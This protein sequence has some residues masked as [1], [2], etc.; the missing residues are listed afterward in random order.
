ML[1]VGNQVKLVSENKNDKWLSIEG[2]LEDQASKIFL[3]NF[4]EHNL[5]FTVE[6]LYG[7]KLY[8]FQEITL[9]AWFKRNFNMS[10]WGRGNSKSWL[11]AVFCPLYLIFNP[12]SKL[13]VCST[14]FR[15]CA[16]PDTWVVTNEGMI[17]LKYVK[18]NIFAKTQN[19]KITNK[20]VNPPEKSIKIK[21]RRNYAIEGL[22]DHKIC[23]YNK[24]SLEFEY[25]ELKDVTAETLI[26]I[27]YGMESWGNLDLLDGYT[28]PTISNKG[29][30]NICNIDTDDIDLYYLMGLILGDGYIKTNKY[31]SHVTLAVGDKD[32]ETM[33]FFDKIIFKLLGDKVKVSRRKN[34]TNCNLIRVN[35]R[36]FVDFLYHV[37][38]KKGALADK[39]II[40]EKI[41]KC[42]KIKIA[43]FLKGLFDSDGSC[44]LRKDKNDV[45][46]CE[47]KLA[48]SSEEIAR[49][50]QTLLLNFGIISSITEEK[51]RGEMYIM[52]VKTYGKKSYSLKIYGY[53]NLKIFAEQIG[54]RLLRKQANLLTYLAKS[55][56]LYKQDSIV[57]PNIGL[58]LKNKY[59]GIS[60]VRDNLSMYTLK[61][62]LEMNILSNE[63]RIKL[64]RICGSKFYIDSIRS[65][66]ESSCETIDIE[67]ENEHCYFGNG[68]INHNS[69]AILYQTEQFLNGK[70]ADLLRQCFPDGVKRKPDEW[71]IEGN[72]G[73]IKALP[74]SN[75]NLRGTRA[76][77]L[78][79]DEMLLI[80]EEL[81]KTILF[82]FL[83]AKSNIQQQMKLDEL[84]ARVMS[85]G[86]I[87]EDQFNFANTMKKVIC[88]SSA[89]YEFEYLYKLY[90]EWI[91]NI[92]ADKPKGRATYFISQMSYEAVP[93][94]LIDE[95]V[96]EEART[97]G[98]STSIF[99]REFCAN[100]INDSSSYFSARKMHECTIPD[101]Q[102]PTIEIMGDLKSKYILAIDPS[103][104]NSPTSDHFA[105]GLVKLDEK[106]DEKGKRSTLIHSYAAAGSNLRDNIAYLHYLL[107]C[108]NIIMIALDNS[109]GGGFR[110]IEACNESP[111]FKN[112]KLELKKWEVD[113]DDPNYGEQ[114]KIGKRNYNLSDHKIVYCI[115]FGSENIRKMNEYLQT[116]IDN[117]RIFFASRVSAN[118][119]KLE[120][121]CQLNIPIFSKM[122][123][124]KKATEMLD[125][126]AEQDDLIQ[127]TKDECALIEVKV[128]PLGNLTFDLPRSLTRSTSLERARRDNYTTLLMANWAVKCYFDVMTTEDNSMQTFTPFTA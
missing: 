7:L 90:K 49:T 85:R 45:E 55:T 124:H 26:P 118:D 110:F 99:K 43:N 72:G 104:S 39:K 3:A 48:T 114:L 125:F 10:I 30:Y 88:L 103:Y 4:L 56:K 95:T 128:S 115:N 62:I 47:L 34:A 50:T 80:T 1:T 120:H 51:A 29:K 121:M 86:N 15:R 42:S 40:P 35:S 27:R 108:F 97:S 112:S 65:I 19:Q 54:F 22:L 117:K 100:F 87:T 74:L 69:R 70:Q 111:L 52:G 68:F 102:E 9:R 44:S 82:P 94:S 66:E 12:E 37:G 123:S 60:W 18:D 76:D 84:K 2:E 106:G 116:S 105:M 28:L 79:V 36:H 91:D 64:N 41:L 57:I 53:D 93:K 77:V 8:P 20:W 21:T 78:V 63:D 16:N 126:I 24:Y 83:A 122:E 89:S 17:Q 32:S 98:M 11:A 119:A 6:M 38:F 13:V 113:F 73:F 101:G 61:K 31:C 109:G 127:L 75:E 46:S 67:V 58:Y 96:V 14:T 25:K 5:G 33:E 81:Y 59:V 92:L 23:T 107:T 71:Q